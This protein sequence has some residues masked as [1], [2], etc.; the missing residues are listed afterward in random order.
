MHEFIPHESDLFIRGKGK[1]FEDALLSVVDGLIESISKGKDCKGASKHSVKA[2]GRED[3][4]TAFSLLESFNAFIDSEGIMPC[5]A[6]SLK[7]SGQGFELVF[8]GK[9]TKF[10]SP[11]KAVTYH[12][13]KAEKSKDKW[14]IEALFDI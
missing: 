3:A 10:S 6:V 4:N 8:L 9:K 12:G 2:N 7:K 5:K 13:L 11:V 14:T 1:T